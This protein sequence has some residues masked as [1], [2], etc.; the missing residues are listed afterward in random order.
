M[1]V[2]VI[3]FVLNIMVFMLFGIRIKPKLRCFIFEGLIV[4]QLL[5]VI[6]FSFLSGA[7]AA[8]V[9]IIALGIAIRT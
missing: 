3:S 8:K 7:Y 9:R 5:S 2:L 1:L 6:S 4:I